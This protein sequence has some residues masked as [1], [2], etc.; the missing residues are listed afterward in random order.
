MP[1]I[2][3][4]RAE[5]F[6]TDYRKDK[7]AAP[8]LLIHGAGGHHEDWPLVLRES[9]NV[10]AVDLAGHGKSPVPA[11]TSVADYA[12]DM[13]SLLDALEIEQAIIAGHSMGGA[14]SLS[15]ALDYPQRVKAMILVGTGAKLAVNPT[16]INGLLDKPEETARMVI[17][18][19]WAKHI[20]DKIKE[21]S[22]QELL[23]TPV[24]IIRGDYLACDG[25][26]VRE[27]LGEI[28]IP[29]LI[30]AGTQDKM[31]PFDWSKTLV[32]NI[33]N[34]KLEMIE[35]GGHMFPLEQPEK[36]RDVIISWIENL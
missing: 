20:P 5:L 18:W 10:I 1:I 6:Y 35:N 9:A 27:R 30:L 25:F 26:D 31:T 23:K 2:K 7:N 4:E 32:D 15:L 24:E 12:V 28:T 34:A 3:T 13:I 19:A 14:I 16:I 29:T 17:K 8:L 11:R 33:P 21:E 22:V 36:I